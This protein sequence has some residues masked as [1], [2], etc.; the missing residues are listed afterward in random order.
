MGVY[1][2]MGLGR[3]PG[4]VIGPLSYLAF[5]YE[6]WNQ[7]DQEFFALSG[8]SSHRESGRKVGDVQAIVIFTTKEI[9]SG[10]LPCVEYIENM[11]GKTIGRRKEGG[12]NV[13]TVLKELLKKTWRKISGNRKKGTIWWCT[14][15]RR[16]IMDVYKKV[17][18]VVQ[19][20][21]S[22][23]GQGKEMWANLTGGNNVTNLALQLAAT[24]TG[25]IGRLYYVQA[26]DAE[27]E[28]CVYYTAKEGYWIDV[29]VMPVELRP[30]SKNVLGLLEDERATVSLDNLYSRLQDKFIVEMSDIS[31]KEVLR[32][33][34]LKALWK[35]RLIAG[36]ESGYTIGPQWK[37]VKPYLDLIVDSGDS[38]LTMQ[39]LR[40]E[41]WLEEEPIDI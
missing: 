4:A 40:N 10:E 39:N 8:E 34:Y 13:K 31:H 23:G 14:V 19:V 5:R 7:S 41:G 28:K 12:E 37:V 2:L 6:R 25:N 9:L 32:D 29:P 17:A 33:M 38:K 35:Q 30:V 18:S 22:Q 20:L 24:L 1:H 16:D 27:A 36:D 3:S 15:D 11:E 26:Q 21:A